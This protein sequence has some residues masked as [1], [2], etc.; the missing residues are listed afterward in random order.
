[1]ANYSESTK[2]A[3]MGLQHH[4]MECYCR[5][6]ECVIFDVWTYL[7]A[8]LLRHHEGSERLDIEDVNASRLHS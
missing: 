3:A 2:H 4:R 8:T 5:L 1:M 7:W 6:K